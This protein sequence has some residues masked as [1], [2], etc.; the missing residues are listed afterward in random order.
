M[1]VVRSRAYRAAATATYSGTGLAFLLETDGVGAFFDSATFSDLNT[2]GNTDNAGGGSGP[3]Y[4]TDGPL[5][6]NGGFAFVTSTTSESGWDIALAN[7]GSV[8]EPGA[9]AILGAGLAGLA[10]MRR[11]KLKAT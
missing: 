10:F 7:T 9:F 6:D 4:T 1:S 5:A 2:A 3:I 8:P 11:R